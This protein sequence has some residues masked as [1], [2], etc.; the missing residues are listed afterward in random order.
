MGLKGVRAGVR[1]GR[2]DG[3]LTRRIL[4]VPTAP[5]YALRQ[6]QGA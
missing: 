5:L 4:T 3:P 2:P 6:W 1:P